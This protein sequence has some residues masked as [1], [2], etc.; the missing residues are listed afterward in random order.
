MAFDIV[1]WRR[2]M[3]QAKSS[4]EVRALVMEVPEDYNASTTEQSTTSSAESTSPTPTE[5][6]PDGSGTAST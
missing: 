6:T 2:R 5:K 3:A 4:E 1:Q